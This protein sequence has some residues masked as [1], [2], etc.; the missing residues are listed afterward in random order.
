VRRETHMTE[1]EK[2]RRVK[3]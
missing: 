1:R 2:L 3:P